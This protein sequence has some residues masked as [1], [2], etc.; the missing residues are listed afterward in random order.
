VIA[1]HPSEDFY[2][3]SAAPALTLSAEA[4]L[5]AG[6]L[7]QAAGAADAAVTMAQ[8]AARQDPSAIQWS[9]NLGAA[10]IV[11]I[12][13][14]ASRAGSPAAQAAALSPAPGEAERLATLARIEPRSVEL[15][16][17]AAAA[18]LLAGDDAS[19]TGQPGLARVRWADAR[20]GLLAAGQPGQPPGDPSGDLLRQLD[21]RLR[22]GRPPVGSG[23]PGERVGG[24]SQIDYRW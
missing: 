19:L 21:D 10:R 12:E 17:L 14:A 2:K 18:A 7:D 4:L 5:R 22:S 20:R 16:R 24:P 23:R 6:R 11:S 3:L 15:A 1:S 8:A 9:D 13:I